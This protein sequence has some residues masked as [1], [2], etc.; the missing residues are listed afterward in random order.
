MKFKIFVIIFILKLKHIKKE[1]RI[2][3]T[4]TTTKKPE[5]FDFNPKF[6]LNAINF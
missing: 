5:E 6:E 2:I 4:K 1:H 3:K